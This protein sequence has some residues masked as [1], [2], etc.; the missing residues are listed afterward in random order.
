MGSFLRAE[1]VV[2][3]SLT[4]SDR[5]LNSGG[6]SSVRL[7]RNLTKHILWQKQI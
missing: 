5:Q 7:R 2:L 3:E 1:K 6:N 4:V